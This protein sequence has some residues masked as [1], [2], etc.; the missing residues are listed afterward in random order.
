MTKLQIK[1]N[2]KDYDVYINKVSNIDAYLNGF[3]DKYRKLVIIIDE[4][5]KELYPEMLLYSKYEVLVLDAKEEQKS[6]NQLD[7]VLKFYQE[8]ELQK[9]DLLV[10]IGGGIIQDIVAFTSK[11][12]YRGVD[13][14]LIPTT[15]LSM[16]DSSIGAKSGINYNDKKNQLG[17]FNAPVEV[18]QNMKFIETLQHDDII[19]GLGEVVKLLIINSLDDFEF[20]KKNAVTLCS[21]NSDFTEVVYRSLIAKKTIIEKDEY[22]SDLRRILNYGHTFGHAIEALTEYKIPHGIGVLWG[23]DLVN[24]IAME[25]GFLNQK[26]YEDINGLILSIYNISKIKI[27]DYDNFISCVKNDKKV[28][29]DFA[30]IVFPEEAGKMIIKEVKIDELLIKNIKKYEQYNRKM[31]IKGK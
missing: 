14:L 27:S 22:E 24:F 31:N 21:N 9:K 15:L 29:G 16:S 3:T 11:I 7:N 23:M 25:R 26:L 18:F 1:S 12:Y 2:S 30:N 8:I 13:Y 28:I 19:S 17:V 4:N 20:I 6:F 5:V 10:A